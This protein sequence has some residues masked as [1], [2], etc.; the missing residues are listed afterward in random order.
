MLYGKIKHLF[1]GGNTSLGFFSYYSDVMTQEEADRLIIIKG[2]PGVGK[3]T[4]MKKVGEEMLQ[5]GYDVEFLHCSSDNNSLDGIKIP[6]LG[7][8]FIDGTAPHVVDPKS[9]GAVDEILNFGEFWN[10][11]G[12][13]IH[14][15]EILEITKKTSAVFAR[16]YK[17]LKAA[18][19]IY[20]DTTVINN[21]ALKKGQLNVFTT[22]LI[23]EIFSKSDISKNEGKQRS[24]FASAITP[25]GLWNF[26][27]SLLT[28][29]NVYELKGGIGTCEER[30]LE[31]IKSA[32]L[33]RGYFVEAYYCAL[34]PYKVEHL[35]IPQLN[36]AI[37]TSNEYH[38][39]TIYKYKT[40][41]LI[42]FYK[43]EILEYYQEDLN[44]NK[45]EFNQLV[46]IALQTISRA[47]AL[48]DKL[49]TFYIPN[50][51]FLAID[52]CYEKIMEKI[53]K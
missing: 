35:V 17:Y 27:D 23:N 51:N 6:M 28:V 46:A 3:S 14:K 4:F 37:T 21:M 16:A 19:A 43:E 10:D 26:L 18:Y 13:R 34:N 8:A 49:E 2:G 52:D 32:A 5:K 45:V 36:V 12:I 11:E 48:H 41:E 7:I 44:Q 25:R 1:P 30:I 38:T 50:V 31:K 24:L 42:Q 47:K 9:P 33:E 53:M 29:E 40:I 39:S 22:D 15:D 20:E